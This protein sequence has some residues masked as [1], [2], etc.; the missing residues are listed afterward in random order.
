MPTFPNSFNSLA[1]TSESEDDFVGLPLAKAEFITSCHVRGLAKDNGINYYALVD[2]DI[3]KSTIASL[4]FGIN[5]TLTGR[6]SRINSIHR[7]C[8]VGFSAGKIRRKRKGTY[9]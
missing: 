9:S 1:E 8:K 7:A 6:T 2:M 3:R 4:L 5:I